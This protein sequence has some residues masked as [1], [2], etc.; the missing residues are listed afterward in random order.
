VCML[1]DGWSDSDITDLYWE[2]RK[3]A[4]EYTTRMASGNHPNWT[5]KQ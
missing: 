2:M 5:R 4:V 3:I 1:G